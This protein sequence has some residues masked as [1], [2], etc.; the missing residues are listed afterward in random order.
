MPAIKAPGPWRM[1]I[2]ICG[3]KYN[4][5]LA[6]NSGGKILDQTAINLIAELA[7]T[8]IVAGSQL[9]HYKIEALLGQGGMGQVFRA[10]DTRLG[11]NV[12]IKVAQEISRAGLN[13]KPGPSPR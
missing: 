11:R 8:Q 9:G 5:L 2:R 4:R 7:P 12:A 13:A 10:T 6:Q 1:P 3:A